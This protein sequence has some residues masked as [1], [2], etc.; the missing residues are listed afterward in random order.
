MVK[1][2]KESRG[3][4]SILKWLSVIVLTLVIGLLIASIF[5]PSIIPSII[6]KAIIDVIP[7]FLLNSIIARIIIIYFLLVI[8]VAT[9]F[10]FETLITIQ[11]IMVLESLKRN[12]ISNSFFDIR[13]FSEKTK[14]EITSQ[15]S[16]EEK[17]LRLK[18]EAEKD[19][20][21]KKELR[22]QALDLRQKYELLLIEN[23]Q[24]KDGTIVEDWRESLLAARK[25]LLK[26]EQRLVA[27]NRSNLRNGIFMAFI[28]VALPAYY[29][30][31]T[32]RAG[33][34]DSG[35]LFISN[36][37]P[38]LSVVLGLEII[39]IF[40]LSLY[41]S[42]E[43]RLERN[44]S[45]LT[46]IELRL[47]AGLMLSDEKNEDKF[48]DLAKIIAQE[49]SKFILGKNESSGGVGTNKI[50]ELLSKLTP[51]IGG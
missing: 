4:L 21:A 5:I 13:S 30:I 11:R 50:T 36:Y 48:A 9:I 22:Q 23:L 35:W 27:R 44:K 42:N 31:F 43:R 19:Q 25:R 8:I 45:D 6:P 37:L 10:D 40:F 20:E 39:A 32:N 15:Y 7:V 14:Q 29:I 38:N 1:E 17:E 2:K 49:D 41:S 34:S 16:V 47:T 46:N 18:I 28:G 33:E 3:V 26:E 51:K 24:T 12:T